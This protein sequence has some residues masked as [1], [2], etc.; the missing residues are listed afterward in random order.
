M[1]WLLLL[2]LAGVVFLNRYIFLEPHL[3]IQLPIFLQKMLRH[4]APH[5]M[6][7]IAAPIIFLEQGQL[8]ESVFD[9]YILA[10]VVCVLLG[11]WWQKLLLNFVLV[12][13]CFYLF[14]IILQ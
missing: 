2:G 13:T 7:V 10:V 14:Q 4:S 11:C 12:L 9:P 8:R 3:N 6:L 5:L 1:S